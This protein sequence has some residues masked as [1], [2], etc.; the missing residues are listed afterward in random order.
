MVIMLLFSWLA[1]AVWLDDIYGNPPQA[2]FVAHK[3][4]IQWGVNRNRLS[5][6]EQKKLVECLEKTNGWYLPNSRT[7]QFEVRIG[8]D[9]RK[10]KL[11]YRW[12]C[13]TPESKV[14]E[15]PL[16]VGSWPGHKLEPLIIAY[17]KGEDGSYSFEL[18]AYVEM[19]LPNELV[20]EIQAVR[21]EF[22]FMADTWHFTKEHGLEVAFP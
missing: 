10:E 9:P 17:R 1:H 8:I 22:G 16:V 12:I 15:L 5:Q 21:A 2:Y 11:N 14:K 4:L 3:K 18:S 13:R 7:A 20:A 6:Q 19:G